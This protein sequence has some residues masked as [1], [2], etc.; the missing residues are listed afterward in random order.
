M[1]VSFVAGKR[2]IRGVRSGDNAGSHSPIWSI[3]GGF[4]FISTRLLNIF[5][6]Y[7]SLCCTEESHTMLAN[8]CILIRNL[9]IHC[10]KQIY[11]SEYDAKLSRT[12]IIFLDVG[13]NKSSNCVGCC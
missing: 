2:N 11:I 4:L 7:A 8:V 6:V 3:Q 12:A 13:S 10:F 9:S 1:Q 5:D